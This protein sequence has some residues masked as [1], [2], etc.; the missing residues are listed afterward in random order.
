[1]GWV[2]EGVGIVKAW[3]RGGGYVGNGEAILSFRGL[4]V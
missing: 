4:P 1:V 2:V 3:G